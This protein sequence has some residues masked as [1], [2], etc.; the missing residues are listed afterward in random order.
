MV[1]V[2]PNPATGSVNIEVERISEFPG[3]TLKLVNNL[4]QTVYVTELTAANQQI[5]LQGWRPGAYFFLLETDGRVLQ[6][7]KLIVR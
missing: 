2:Y 3:T 4:G 7:G 5:N 6:S 1:R